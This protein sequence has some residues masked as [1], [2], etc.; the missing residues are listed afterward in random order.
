MQAVSV[1][2]PPPGA[3]RIALV[4]DSPHSGT[5]YPD[6]FGHAIGRAALRRSEDTHV[7]TLWA[8]VVD[9]GA[10]LVCAHFPRSYLDPNRDEADIDVGMID[11]PW[12]HEV[13]A[14]HQCRALG[15]GLVWRRTPSH[16]EIYD[17]KLDPAEVLA[18]IENCWRPYRDALQRELTDAWERHRSWYHLNL[19]SMPSNAYERL[20]LPGKPLADI[21]LGDRAGTTCAP[22]FLA[23]VGDAFRVE[24]LRVAVNDP[25]EGLELIRL[26]G[27]PARN[28]HSLQ[29]EINRAIYMDEA[30]R[31]PSAG[32]A[33][34][35]EAI[36]RVVKKVAQYV[37]V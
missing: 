19:H 3:R 25:Y 5:W 32:F 22:G 29:I 17:R 28:R 24:G 10:S 11:G 15:N 31:E 14:S 16:E 2:V 6:D 7:D 21:V 35:S 26:S 36:E 23:A 13:R 27:D 20:G 4:C 30:T 18:R 34:L 12:P 8:S 37:Q 33:P 9:A 1:R